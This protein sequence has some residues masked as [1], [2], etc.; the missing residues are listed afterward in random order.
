MSMGQGEEGTGLGDWGGPYLS[1]ALL[2][3]LVIEDR[4]GS[5]SAIRIVDRYEVRAIGPDVP[6]NMPELN[7]RWRGNLLISFKSG[8]ARGRHEV[9]I[10]PESPSGMRLP[11]IAHPVI[12]E[13]DERGYNL[14]APL[15]LRLDQEG[16]YWFDILMDGRLVTRVPLRI[17]YLPT[18]SG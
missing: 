5:L 12:F 2:C 16:L 3:E 10:R 17:V 7:E 13:G 8:Q 18:R 9:R 1:A 4:Q 14:I 11:E 6:D 15:G